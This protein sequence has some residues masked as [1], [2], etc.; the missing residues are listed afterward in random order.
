MVAEARTMISFFR[1]R[2]SLDLVG[3]SPIDKSQKY[4]AL[5]PVTE[6]GYHSPC[7]LL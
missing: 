4:E 5:P 3:I 7:L 6:K 1:L 2:V